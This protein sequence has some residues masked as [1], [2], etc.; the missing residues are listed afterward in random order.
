MFICKICNE[1]F[2]KHICSLNHLR[3]H[4]IRSHYEL[5]K[6]YD[7][8]LKEQ[9]EEICILENCSNI[10]KFDGLNKGYKNWP[11]KP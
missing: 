5:K 8:Y 4:K 3:K 11:R 10:C 9:N 1:K 7:L 6:Y 2:E